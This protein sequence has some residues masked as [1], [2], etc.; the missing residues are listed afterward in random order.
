MASIVSQVWFKNRR[1]KWRKRERC[2]NSSSS[3]DKDN[4]TDFYK[5]DYQNSAVLYGSTFLSPS[6]CWNLPNNQTAAA[7]AA[8]AAAAVSSYQY[9]TY[10]PIQPYANPSMCCSSRDTSNYLSSP[11]LSLLP[12]YGYHPPCPTNSIADLRLKAKQ[13]AASIAANIN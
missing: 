12:R 2:G 9:P 8:A 7:A 6:H 1:A 4:F 11:N 5:R 10:C 13:H 3:Y